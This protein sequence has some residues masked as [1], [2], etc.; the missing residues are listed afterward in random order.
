MKHDK[1]AKHDNR[2]WLL[3]AAAAG[4]AGGAVVASMSRRRRRR[5]ARLGDDRSQ[6]GSWENEGGNV[7][8]AIDDTGGVA[9]STGD[10]AI[11]P[12]VSTYTTMPRRPDQPR[13]SNPSLQEKATPCDMT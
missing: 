3:A 13:F 6:T 8:P 4:V 10:A 7:T 2:W 11:R 12:R 1:N 5:S 9:A